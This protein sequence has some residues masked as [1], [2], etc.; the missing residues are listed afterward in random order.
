MRVFVDG[1]AYVRTCVRLCVRVCV[2]VCVRMCVRAYV[3]ACLRVYCMCVYARVRACVQMYV[4]GS[5]SRRYATMKYVLCACII[6]S[7]RQEICFQRV[8]YDFSNFTQGA[9]FAVYSQMRL[10]ARQTVKTIYSTTL[11]LHIFVQTF[12]IYNHTNKYAVHR[13]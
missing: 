12:Q 4:N 2:F 6:R 11:V 13:L 7:F 3:R 5:M 1:H 10:F 9:I 8:T